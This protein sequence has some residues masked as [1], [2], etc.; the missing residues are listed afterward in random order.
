[1][2]ILSRQDLGCYLLIALAAFVLA[3][4]VASE[5]KPA[6]AGRRLVSAWAMSAAAL[7]V[8]LGLYWAASGALPSMFRQLVW[9]PLTRYAET[10]SLPMPRLGFDQPPEAFLL[11]LLFYLPPAVAGATAIWLLVSAVRRRFCQEHARVAFIAALS[12]SF[13]FQVLIR[14]DVF[15]LLITLAPFFVLCG[16]VLD[17]ASSLLERRIRKVVGPE[18]RWNS[19]VAG[20]AVL[21]AALSSAA[22]FLWFTAP[23]LLPRPDPDARTLSIDRGGVF[24]APGRASGIEAV[25]ETIQH[26]AEPDRSILCLPYQPMFYFLAERRN[27]TRWNYI[28]PGDQSEED[29]RAL[30]EQAREDPPAVVVI[31]GWR[32]VNEYAPVILEYVDF[33]YR[34]AYDL[35]DM[36]IY[37]PK[38]R[39][40]F[41]PRRL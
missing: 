10:S 36:A 16:C 24:L 29:H 11:A 41:W 17:R 39:G 5:A 13:Y 38:Q 7:A 4:R 26:Y 14:S 34:L 28:W 20:P 23:V 33:E 25:K 21:L 30:I 35:S 1:L 27:P 32:E 12:L 9:F 31:A 37:L 40:V 8:P 22:L 15:H 19:F 6:V 2:T 18:A 3:L